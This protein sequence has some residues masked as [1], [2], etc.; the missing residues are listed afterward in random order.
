MALPRDGGVASVTVP[1][2]MLPLSAALP[3]LTRARATGRGHRATVFW[4]AAALLG[5]HFTAR[6]LLL[7]GLSAEDHDAWRAAPLRESDAEQVRML[8]AAMPPEAHA[9]PLDGA[10]DIR[11]PG[12]ERLLRAFLDAVAD[13]LPRSP[14]AP[15]LAGG[16]AY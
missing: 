13:T 2:V 14:A 15:L 1:A 10:G 4:G 6:G 16:P 3:L 9:V 8:A 11:L 7:P 5:L 12:P